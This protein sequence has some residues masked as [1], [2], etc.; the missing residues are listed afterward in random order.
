MME[1]AI[2]KEDVRK[3][4]FFERENLRICYAEY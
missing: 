3:E 2:D 1:S 4:Y